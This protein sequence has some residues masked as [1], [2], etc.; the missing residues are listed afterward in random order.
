MT[1]KHYPSM[2]TDYHQNIYDCSIHVYSPSGKAI[3]SEV[4]EW[5]RSGAVHA[6]PDVKI[7][8]LKRRPDFAQ[9]QLDQLSRLGVPVHFSK[10]VAKATETQDGVVVE[11]EDGS[12]YTGDVCIAA[13]GIG[14]LFR[15]HQA[16][17]ASDVQNSGYAIARV[18]YPRT[19]LKDPSPAQRLLENVDVQPEFRVYLAADIHLIL[20]LTKDY[21]GVALTH[22]VLYSRRARYSPHTDS[23]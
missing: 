17:G 11:T 6:A 9:M 15:R 16:S 2:H 10:K 7:S 22:K 1:L 23:Q 4:P 21:V 8:F 5:N 12:R 19:E 18:A 3:K 14:S 13:D 20:F